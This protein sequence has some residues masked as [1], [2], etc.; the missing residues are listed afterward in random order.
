MSINIR[1]LAANLDPFLRGSTL[2]DNGRKQVTFQIEGV[3]LPP[4]D[5]PFDTAK[6]ILQISPTLGKRL[7]HINLRSFILLVRTLGDVVDSDQWIGSTVT[8]RRVHYRG[9]DTE[10]GLLV[11][12][13]AP[14]TFENGD[15]DG[16]EEVMEDTENEDE[17]T[18]PPKRK[19]LKPKP[20]SVKKP[21]G[22]RRR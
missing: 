7:V 4:D 17:D 22:K 14:A 10:W 15:F 12:H 11:E 16:D 2:Y 8:M 1:K 18:L 19:I 20:V 6:L 21:L 5:Y 13:A 3:S 9:I